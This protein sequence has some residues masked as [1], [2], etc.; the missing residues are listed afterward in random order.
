[1]SVDNLFVF[2]M[3]FQYFA[4]PSIYQQRVLFWGIMGSIVASIL[5]PAV[6][7]PM[8]EEVDEGLAAPTLPSAGE[9][10]EESEEEKRAA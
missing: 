1:L 3:I 10:A 4:V 9:D 2:L 7:A 5:F 8:P 6:K